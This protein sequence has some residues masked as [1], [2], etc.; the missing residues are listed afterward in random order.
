[1]RSSKIS[2][3]P[4]PCWPRLAKAEYLAA[5]ADSSRP[6]SP[7]LAGID[8]LG[9]ARTGTGKTAAFAIPILERLQAA[10]ESGKVRRP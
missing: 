6:D 4:K 8:V 1:M 7:R 5:H 2:A 9:Q 10:Q 3:F